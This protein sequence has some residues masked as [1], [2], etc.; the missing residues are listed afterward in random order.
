MATLNTKIFNIAIDL[1]YENND[2]DKILNLIK[3]LNER[4]KKY[5]RL[6]GKVTD[7]KIFILLCL[8]LEDKISDLNVSLNNKKSH[9]K[10]FLENDDKLES[11]TTD[12]LK[13]NDKINDLQKELNNKSEEE[14][15]IMDL[16]DIINKDIKY[17]NEIIIKNYNE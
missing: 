8:E 5:E 10:K 17:L 16:I 2:K 14:K 15:K 11:L 12:N 13:L 1:N 6:K 7:S 4:L 3:N 9:E